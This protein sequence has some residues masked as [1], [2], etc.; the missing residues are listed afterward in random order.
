VEQTDHAHRRLR[1]GL[2]GCSV[3]EAI[4]ILTKAG[5]GTN[6]PSELHSG[7]KN[8]HEWHKWYNQLAKRLLDKMWQKNPDMSADEAAQAARR[9][10]DVLGRAA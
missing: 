2:L 7:W 5:R 6:L 4:G 10:A 8:W 9:M 1:T 3:A